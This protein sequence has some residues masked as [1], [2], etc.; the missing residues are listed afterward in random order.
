M[1]YLV[2]FCNKMSEFTQSKHLDKSIRQAVVYKPLSILFSQCLVKKIIA[3]SV[4]HPLMYA[5]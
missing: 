2:S 4:E 5:I 1:P 3:L